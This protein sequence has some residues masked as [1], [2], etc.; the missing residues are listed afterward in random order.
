LFTLC[1]YIAAL[2]FDKLVRLGYNINNDRPDIIKGVFMHKNTIW[3]R[4][5][6][7]IVLVNLTTFFGFNMTSVG[8]PVYAAQLGA[9]DLVSGLVI[10]VATVAAMLMRPFTGV[11]LDRYGR[12]GILAFSIAL[13]SIV[14]AAYAVFPLLGVLLILR[15]LHGIGWGLSSTA[16]STIAADVIPKK[17]FAEGMGYFALTSAVALAV[18]PALSIAL[19]QHAGMIPMIAIASGCTGLSFV[20]ALFEQSGQTPIN[21]NKAKIKL[22]DL[23]DKRALLP[24]GIMLLLTFAYASIITFIA[25]HGQEQNVNRVYLFFVVY[26]IVTIITRPIIGKMIDRVG[27]YM[28]GIL[29][30]LGLA[31]TMVLIAF[32]SNVFMFCIAGVFAG[33]GL[34][35]GMGT[36]Q[37]MAVAAVP[38]ERRGVATSTFLLGFDAGIAAGATFAGLLADTMGYKGMYL[39]MALFPLTGCIVFIALGK[40]RI[41]AYSGK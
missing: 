13:M 33:L 9:S 37:T 21:E 20:L 38:K 40:K 10:T 23:F 25:L 36:L 14:I 4:D 8:L 34:G 32:S 19:V 27:Y 5:F 6:I 16:S 31:I 12:K 11:M 22:S 41:S 18:A 26:A 29:A 30:A 15:V 7:I 28:P 2:F 3:T 39:V 24:S 17:R 1:N 35:T